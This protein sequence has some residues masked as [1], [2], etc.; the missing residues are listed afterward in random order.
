[1]RGT[2]KAGAGDQLLVS[3][4]EGE[5][6]GF[7]VGPELGVFAVTPARIDDIKQGEFVGLT[8]IQSGGRRVALEAHL[9]ARTCGASAKVIMPGT[10]SRSPT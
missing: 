4:R 5:V 10:S 2:H 8:S 3:S 1:M 9:F 7:E 6:M